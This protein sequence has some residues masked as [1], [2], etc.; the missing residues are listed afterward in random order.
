MAEE[1]RPIDLLFML[2]SG[3]SV[4]GVIITAAV[5]AYKTKNAHIR[6]QAKFD[7]VRKQAE[8]NA[9]FAADRFLQDFAV[10]E[11][12]DLKDTNEELRKR[13]DRTEQ[14]LEQKQREIER[15][16]KQ[17]HLQEIKIADLEKANADLRKQLE[18]RNT[19]ML[20]IEAL[21]QEKERLLG[22]LKEREN[23]V[24]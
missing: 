16:N 14:L 9:I 3:S 11:I 20:E 7:L 18:D 2:L 13:L 12:Q 5:D 22:L 10:T 21:K 23:E 15:L 1:L 17:Y 19:L 24:K 8:Q 6:D 4:V